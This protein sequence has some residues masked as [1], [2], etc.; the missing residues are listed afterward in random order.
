MLT[1]TESQML[2]R[3][4]LALGFDTLRDDCTV[5]STSG[6]NVDAWLR[7]RLR[8]W[9]L[10]LL[11][12][13]PAWL[14]PVDEAA[15]SVSVVA[16]TSSPLASITPPPGTRRVLSV[17]LQ[18]WSVPAVPVS[19]ADAAHRLGRLASPFCRPGARDPLA[20]IRDDGTLLVAPV[21]IPKVESLKVIPTPD[22]YVL[23]ESLIPDTFPFLSAH[24][25]S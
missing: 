2:A 16:M 8:R 22:G 7:P 1:L 5:E 10:D 3:C 6:I 24:L 19:E 12:T 25:P 14:L 15:R 11:D 18:G 20:V 13:A 17:K 4:R 21:D 23:D 9:Y